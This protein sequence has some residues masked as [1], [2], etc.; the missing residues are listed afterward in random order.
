[1]TSQKTKFLKSSP[2]Q[3]AS[4]RDSGEKTRTNTYILKTFLSKNQS[5]AAN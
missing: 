3:K 5:V 1:M 4:S 2:K